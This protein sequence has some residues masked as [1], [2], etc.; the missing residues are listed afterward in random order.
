MPLAVAAS[1]GSQE[2]VYPCLGAFHIL[3]RRARTHPDCTHDLAIHHYGDA[4]GDN[5]QP[6]ADRGVMP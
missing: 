1:L 2:A 3:R 6:P 5:K 4:A